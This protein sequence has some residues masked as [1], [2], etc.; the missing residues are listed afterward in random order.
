MPFAYV[1]E[2]GAS[3]HLSGGSILVRKD[4]VLLA[5]WELIHLQAL[6]L[7]GP[8]DISTPAMT[9]LLKAGV[10]TAFMTTS[11]RLLGQL[12][13]A[14]AGNVPLRLAQYR[15]ATDPGFR[16]S[17]AVAVVRAKL[18]AMSDLLERYA[19]NY[20]EV[21]LDEP[22]QSIKNLRERLDDAPDIPAL[23]GLE[24]AAAA[25]YF[26]GFAMTNRSELPFCGRSTRPPKDPVNAMLSFGY[27]L[28]GN[29]IWSL[30]DALGFDPFLGFYHSVTPNRPSLALDLIEPF[31]HAIIDRMVLRAI[32]LRRFQAADF[33][34]EDG[35]VLLAREASKRFLAEYERS[36]QSRARDPGDDRSA[37]WRDL[38]RRRCERLALGL[39]EADRDSEA[40]TRSG[41]CSSCF[42]AFELDEPEEDHE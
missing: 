13:P 17:Q 31:R 39:V 26:K 25:A 18:A 6:I 7:L 36:I 35:G 32:N 15:L 29:E 22:R 41:E 21:P 23:M 34:E 4:G 28:L 1:T 11:G 12:T 30:L 20:P 42:S 9:A 10:E 37:T 40:A 5:E 27:V 38:I 19:D 33:C 2:P 16:F 3:I 8:A 14:K 24:G